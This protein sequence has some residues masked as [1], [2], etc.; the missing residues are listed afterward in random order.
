MKAT[1]TFLVFL[2]GGFTALFAYNYQTVYSDRV[3][4]FET[5]EFHGMR[6]DSVQIIENDSIFYPMKRILVRQDNSDCATPYGSSWLGEKII[7]SEDWNNF[8]YEEDTIRIKIT[9]E[10]N[11][12]WVC[13]ISD[14]YSIEATVLEHKL[15]QFLGVEDSVKIISFQ[16]YDKDLQPMDIWKEKNLTISK[17]YG[18]IQGLDLVTFLSNNYLS[19][20]YYETYTLAGLSNPKIGVQNLTWF[21]VWDFQPGD[22]L[23][24]TSGYHD[25]EISGTTNYIINYLSREDF[26]DRILYQ[27][28]VK[29]NQYKGRF[30]KDSLIYYTEYDTPQEILPDESFD[31]LPKE[32]IISDGSASYSENMFYIGGVVAKGPSYTYLHKD[33]DSDFCWRE[34]IVCFLG[35]YYSY[36]QKGLGYYYFQNDITTGSHRTLVYYKKGDVESGTPLILETG[37]NEIQTNSPVVYNPANESLRI[38]IET[39]G[40]A[41]QLELVDLTGR[42][43]IQHKLISASQEVPLNHLPKG[44]YLYRLMEQGKT[45]NSGKIVK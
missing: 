27:I 15:Q 9:A 25:Y 22:E 7:A 14:N 1:I 28:H 39:L 40:T 18:L 21:D 16:M 35:E 23:H 10:L 12:S 2:L 41:V 3:A 32:V 33:Y 26:P 38:S 6:M 37:I 34:A 24:I 13:F 5:F 44:I 29:E 19:A 31:K 4:M 30:G 43:L 8:I 11:E 20:D 36:H 42:V 45:I 17:N